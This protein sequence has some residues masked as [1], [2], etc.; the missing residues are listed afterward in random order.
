MSEDFF[1][2][3][4][5]AKRVG[6]KQIYV[7]EKICITPYKVSKNFSVC[8]SVCLSVCLSVINFDPSYGEMGLFRHCF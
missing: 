7:K 1:A 4:L 3:P 6:R 5:R 8:P 2:I